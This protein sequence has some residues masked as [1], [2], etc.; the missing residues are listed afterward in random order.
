MVIQEYSNKDNEGTVRSSDRYPYYVLLFSAKTQES[1]EEK[2]SDMLSL[3]KGDNA[4]GY[5]LSEISY[6]LQ[7]G[8]QH[9]NHRLAVVIQGLDDTVYILGQS[10]SKEKLPNMFRGKVSRDFTEQ[11]AIKQYI[12][13]LLSQ[14]REL[15]D[16]SEKYREIM[17]AL[18]D[19]YCQG[20]EIDWDKL[21]GEEKPRRIS[22]PT[23]PFAREKYW[24]MERENDIYPKNQESIL[25]TDTLIKEWIETLPEIAGNNNKTTPS[26]NVSDN[27]FEEVINQILTS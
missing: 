20:Y 17:Y 21:Y 15:K 13:D 4:K 27:K 19:F 26:L 25:Q 5:N 7:A 24:I 9:F 14:S 18:S 1:L 23:Y 22:L 12:Q 10:G 6:T 11:S 16:N 3:L 8:R 2:I